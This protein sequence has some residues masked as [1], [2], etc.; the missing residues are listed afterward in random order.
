MD[1]V[2]GKDCY[3]NEMIWCYSRP[4]SPKQQQLSRVHDTIHWYSR[5][6][7]W[8]FNPDEIRQPYAESS[9]NREG[10]SA[11][12]SKVADGSVQ[13]DKKG[14]F[15]ESWIYIPPLKGNAKEYCGYPT[16]KP[17]RLLER[18][19]KASSNPDDMILDPFCGCATAL[20]A[21]NR[22]QRQW[23]GIDLSPLA[24]KLVNDRII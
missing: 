1:G 8:T 12:A 16:Q 23:A 10:Y 15:P 19:L 7:A 17:L 20:M 14:K 22:L 9:R 3:R 24:V 5:G 4:S 18:I 21:A 13:L 11:K 6:G 2:F